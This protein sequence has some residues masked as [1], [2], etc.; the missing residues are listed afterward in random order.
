M[1]FTFYEFTLLVGDNVGKVLTVAKPD[2]QNMEWLTKYQMPNAEVGLIIPN[3]SNENR[4]IR[5]EEKV[6]KRGFNFSTSHYRLFFYL[7]PIVSNW[8][9]TTLS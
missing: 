7:H 9:Y 4:K 3:C 2:I 5:I 6:A 1:I 8:K